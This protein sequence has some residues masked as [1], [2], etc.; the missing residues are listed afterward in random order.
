[1]RKKDKIHLF[2]S[3]I[4]STMKKIFS[5]IAIAVIAG[6]AFV[7]CDKEEKDVALTG[8]SLSQKS[9]DLIAGEQLTLIVNYNPGNASSKPAVVWSSSDT[10]AAKVVDGVVYA[11]NYGE[12][13]ITATAGEF[14]D[15]C[16]VSI[17][18]AEPDEG[19][20]DYA[21][22]GT[23]HGSNWNKS[24]KMYESDDD[25]ESYVIKNITLTEKDKFKIWYQNSWDINRGGVFVELGQ[26][27]DVIQY[28][29]D[30][31]PGLIGTYDIWYFKDLEQICIMQHNVVPFVD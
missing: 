15:S 13:V 23:F 8:I 31:Q 16:I 9:A 3:L 28:G 6:V 12:F 5:V 18:Y 10:T 30:I 25:D 19:E 24:L 2:K 21:I 27:F 1:M 17:G 22:I 4:Y 29:P 20:S 11:K 26:G 14:V 7:S